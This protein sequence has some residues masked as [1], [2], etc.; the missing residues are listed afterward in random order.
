M[1]S[2]KTELNYKRFYCRDCCRKYN[3]RTG[4]AFNFLE[5]PTDLVLMIVLWRLPY[6]LSLRYVV[7]L[8][9][10]RSVTLTN[11]TVRGTKTVSLVG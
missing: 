4:T 2:S 11:E 8:C 1:L 5:Y 3:E 9:S 7:E 10:L 6:A